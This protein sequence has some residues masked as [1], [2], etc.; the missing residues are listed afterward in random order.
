M[1]TTNTRNISSF[2]K[3]FLNK[4][5]YMAM[6]MV[7]SM[8][9]TLSLVGMEKGGTGTSGSNWFS[10]PLSWLPRW[11]GGSTPSSEQQSQQP[12]TSESD[13]LSEQDKQLLVLIT[14]MTRKQS[15][16]SQ[17]EEN[18]IRTLA[19]SI[20]SHIVNE[21]IR[22]KFQGTIESIIDYC[23]SR[24]SQQQETTEDKQKVE[25]W[26]ESLKRILKDKEKDKAAATSQQLTSNS[27][28]QAL[29]NL[30][31]ALYNVAREI[32]ASKTTIHNISAKIVEEIRF[33]E[34]SNL[35]DINLNKD[36]L[37]KFMERLNTQTVEKMRE[38]I[39]Y[40]DKQ[41]KGEI[42]KYFNSNGQK[43]NTLQECII[44]EMSL[45][46]NLPEDQKILNTLNRL[47][48]LIENRKDDAWIPQLMGQVIIALKRYG[49]KNPSPQQPRTPMVQPQQPQQPAL[50]TKE[51][52][53]TRLIQLLYDLTDPNLYEQVQDPVTYKLRY[54]LKDKSL[55]QQY[56]KDRAEIKRIAQE[57]DPAGASK[58]GLQESLTKA[59]EDPFDTIN[60]GY[61]G[62]GRDH[63]KA[64]V[65]GRLKTLYPQ[66]ENLLV[67]PSKTA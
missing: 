7:V 51:Q 38:T 19:Q 60:N 26:L 28:Q 45:I 24:N 29:G 44:N 16:P 2:T 65:F 52:R 9:L 41:L 32:Q 27:L 1:N 39:N 59:C 57:L 5:L 42:R 49:A 8:T 48:E 67:L 47:F 13:Q 31:N 4:F 55:Q 64:W 50:G 20:A 18:Q 23:Y 21:S 35:A 37:L 46:I 10:W 66:F 11:G 61:T 15:L 63:I 40:I 54:P 17:E 58:K 30:T 25:R 6:I 14:S 43:C 56:D 3:K 36:Q 34:K 62:D 53:I 22:G 33:Y 12:I